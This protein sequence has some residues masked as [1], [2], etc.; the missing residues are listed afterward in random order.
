[1]KMK[2]KLFYVAMLFILLAQG[3][4]AQSSARYQALFVYNFTRYIQWPSLGSQDFVIGVLGKSQIFSELQTVTANKKTGS[5][6]IVVKQFSSA[7][8]IANCQILIVANEASSQVPQLAALLQSKNTLIITER[9]GLSKKG[10][11]IC[12]TVDDGKQRFEIS[13]SNVEKTGLMV[14]NQ[15]LEMAI[16]TD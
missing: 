10:A 1:M 3:V 12:F 8:E 5:N 9:S 15:L 4:S 7:G 16:V 14:N 11:S 2:K 6:S 13:K